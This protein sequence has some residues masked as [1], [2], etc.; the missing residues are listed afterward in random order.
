MDDTMVVQ[1]SDGGEGSF[2]QIG[3]VGFVVGAF[4]AYPIEELTSQS[5]V[6]D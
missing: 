2:D 5:E 6:G 4:A 3:G 1:V